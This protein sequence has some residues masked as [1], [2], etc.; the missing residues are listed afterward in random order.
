MLGLAISSSAQLALDLDTGPGDQGVREATAK[1]GDMVTV[2]LV[3]TTPVQDLVGVEVE[4]RFDNSQVAFKGFS[5][6]GLLQ[7]AMPLPR[8]IP[9]G[10]NIAV[11]IMGNQASAN[12]SSTLGEL[13]FEVTNLGQGVTIQL[14]KGSFGT[15]SG[16]KEFPLS[17]GVK[18]MDE[19]AGKM[20][21]GGQGQG[22]PPPPPG[23]SFG[24]PPQGQG[25]PPQGGQQGPPPEDMRKMY[26]QWKTSPEA[27]DLNGDRMINESDFKIFVDSMDQGQGGP[28]PGGMGQGGPPPGGMGQGG[29]PPVTRTP[30]GGM[31]QGGPPPG[32]MGQGGPPPGGMGQGGPPP[33][34]M[35][36]GGPPPGGMGQGGPHMGGSPEEMIKSLPAALQPSFTKTIEVEKA[37]QKAHMEAELNMLKSV[38]ATLDDTKRFLGRATKEEKAKIAEVLMFFD[39]MDGPGG[40]GDHGP[41]PGPGGPPGGRGRGGPPAGG[42]GAPGQEDAEDLVSRMIKQT[43]EDIK[44][45][46]KMMQEMMR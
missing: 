19:A 13:K 44:H 3:T 33:G 45:L 30:P 35:G 38:R 32:G 15:T 25:Q 2:Q 36:Q 42:M 8:P 20:G 11:A 14:V 7:G 4:V 46:E 18:L 23:G 21:M 24:G 5:A 16:T 41:G 10:V 17:G 1:T 27:K 34:G 6:M 12:E 43:D 31:G 37:S 40:P 28:P 9:G 22:S 29:P 39:R 26:E